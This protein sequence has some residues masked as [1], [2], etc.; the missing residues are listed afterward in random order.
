MPITA[1]LVQFENRAV[2]GRKSFQRA[3]QGDPIKTMVQA[4]ILAAKFAAVA[5]MVC[6]RLNGRLRHGLPTEVHQSRIHSYSMKPGGKGRITAEG[7]K[8]SERL[9]ECFLRKVVCVGRIVGHAEAN[10]VDATSMRFK[11]LGKRIRLPC[12]CASYERCL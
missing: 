5:L 1:N 8:L 10:G 4:I 6:M 2:S 11:Q 9:D 12:Q 3:C 7:G